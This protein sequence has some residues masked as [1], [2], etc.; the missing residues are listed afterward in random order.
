MAESLRTRLQRLLFNFFPAYRRTGGRIT[1]VASDWQEIRVKLPLNWRTRN[2]H[3]TT[4]GGSM[5]AAV[6]PIYAMMLIRILG[7]EYTVW[8]RSASIDFEK[9]GESTL[10]ARFVLDDEEI[11]TIRERLSDAGSLTRDYVVDLTDDEGVVHAEVEK[12]IYVRKD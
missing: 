4:F 12:T 9:P 11:T 2:Y 8:D 1:Y 10:Y 7:E 3:G 6:D 5:Y